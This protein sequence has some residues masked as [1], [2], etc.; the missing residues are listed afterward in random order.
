[1]EILFTNAE[2]KRLRWDGMLWS[3]PDMPGAAAS[4]NLEPLG[5]G[6]KH[7]SILNRARRQAEEPLGPVEMTRV[8]L[9]GMPEEDIGEDVLEP[10]EE[11]AVRMESRQS[12][13]HDGATETSPAGGPLA[14]AQDYL[15]GSV[16]PDDTFDG[17]AAEEDWE[18]PERQWSQ[19]HRWCGEQGMMLD[20]PEPEISGGREHDVVFDGEKECWVKYTK[21]G[22]AGYMVDWHADGRPW[23]RNALPLEYLARLTRQNELFQD[24][25]KLA[26]L[27]R[28]G[29]G[30]WRIVTTQPHVRGQRATMQEISEGMK[31]LGLVQMGW[32]GIG[33]EDSTS[34]RIGRFGVW[35]VHPANV[36]MGGNGVVVP[37]DVIITELPDGFPPCHFHPEANF[38]KRSP[39][40]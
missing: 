18:E 3:S 13:P 32:K 14:E 28:E 6:A 20:S 17:D 2:G 23:L 27:W 8:D 21:P 40:L 30:G 39:K 4:L 35:D 34:W 26:G 1:M 9:T 25:I 7:C 22:M 11:L 36:I 5:W 15:G 31:A 16:C 29:T 37:V 19:L 10:E 24:D 33:Y 12:G 38:L